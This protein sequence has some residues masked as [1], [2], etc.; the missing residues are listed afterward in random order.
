MSTDFLSRLD[1]IVEVADL[2]HQVAC[3][4]GG[5]GNREYE[6]SRGALEA[7][8]TARDTLAQSDDPTSARVVGNI[9]RNIVRP[10][11]F[12]FL[13]LPSFKGPEWLHI[14]DMN[15]LENG[16]QEHGIRV[17][18][19]VVE[20]IEGTRAEVLRSFLERNKKSQ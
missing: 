18:R 5:S 10:R 1:A 17:Q 13:P 19:E 14:G 2:E 7:L 15:E 11:L 8:R 16:E 9:V 4:H 12:G 6:S 3:L 20:Q